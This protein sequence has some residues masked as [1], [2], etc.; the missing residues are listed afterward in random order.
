MDEIEIEITLDLRVLVII[1]A[2]FV[3]LILIIHYLLDIVV[4]SFAKVLGMTLVTVEPSQNVYGVGET[5]SITLCVN[6]WLRF[7]KVDL[8]IVAPDGQIIYFSSIPINEYCS[9]V[10][11]QNIIKEKGTY[12]I[13]VKREEKVHATNTFRIGD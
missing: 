3:I 7:D 1:A 4:L 8:E 2:L 10:I 6:S 11:L 12:L 13:I 9:N 5:V